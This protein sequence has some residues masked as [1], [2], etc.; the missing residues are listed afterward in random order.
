MRARVLAP[1][2]LLISLFVLIVAACSPGV[3]PA[4][5]APVT[6]AAPAAPTTAPTSAPA[7]TATPIPAATVA[8]TVAPSPAVE[9]SP[10]PAIMPWWNDHVF[11]EIFVRSFQD[12]NG[13]G[14]GDLKGL[15]SRLDYLNDGKPDTSG[16]LG[17]TGIWLMPIMPSPSYHGYDVTDYK[18]INPEYGTMDE[19]KQLVGEAHKR[20]IKV[21]IDLVLNHTSSQHPWFIEAQDPKSPKHDWY[22]WSENPT[23]KNWHKADNGLYYYGYFGD[24]M[25]DLNYNNPQVTEAVYDIVRFWLEDVKVDGFR[26]DAVK[27]LYED[28]KRV[29]HAPATFEWLGK[30][31]KY[32][33]SINPDAFTVGEVWDDTGTVAK[34]VPGK[35]DVAFEFDMAEAMIQSAQRRE[36]ENVE[37]AQTL[38]NKTYPPGQFAPFL[39]NHDQN[40]TRSRMIEEGQAFSAASLELL[41]P[42]V[43]FIYYGEEIGMQGSKPDEN[44]R[45][46]MQWTADGGFTTG[47]PWN[48]YFEDVATRNVEAQDKD[49]ASLLNHYRNLLRLRNTYPALR[50]GDWREV[51]VPESAPSVYSFMRSLGDERFLVLINLSKDPVSDYQLSL[52]ARP[53][54]AAPARPVKAE[55]VFSPTDPT[56]D[57]P[58]L[59]ADGFEGYKP[60]PTLPP[61]STFVIRYTP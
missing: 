3:A 34:Y 41:Y 19:F 42:G 9:A 4:T 15:I 48:A 22:V 52:E 26:L 33:K 50:T 20:G 30:F 55:V 27:Y 37:R 6:I 16:D 51:T 54:A 18:A 17:V 35:L 58:T 40:R 43:P 59:P 24:Q 44:I 56:V 57:V 8:P 23:G 47:T 10:A 45:R 12:S 14:N 32:M 61:Y 31:N 38:V 28:G 5:L 21:I 1:K 39:A 13:D 46:P 49:G 36:R 7:P 2:F 60:I 25:P 11:Y 53:G 29:Q